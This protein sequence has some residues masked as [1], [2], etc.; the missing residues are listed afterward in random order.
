MLSLSLAHKITLE[1]QPG[2][3]IV[4]G[5]L[6]PLVLDKRRPMGEPGTTICDRP[7]LTIA[8]AAGPGKALSFAQL[9]FG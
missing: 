5:D 2:E 7:L 9:F 1:I 3:Q 6:V 4:Q 8:K